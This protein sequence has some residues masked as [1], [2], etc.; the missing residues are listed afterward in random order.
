VHDNGTGDAYLTPPSDGAYKGVQFFQ[1]R[2]NTA[3]AEFNGG[4][5]WHGAQTDDPSTPDVDESAIGAGAFYFPVAKFEMGGN[6]DM[7]FVGLVAD[8]IEIY[9]TGNVYVTGGGDS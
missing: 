1:A 2:D 7:N 3:K 8:K 6:G 5:T 4:T 9:G